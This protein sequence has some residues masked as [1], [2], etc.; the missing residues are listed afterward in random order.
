LIVA[1]GSNDGAK[2]PTW[3]VPATPRRSPY[4]GG[5]TTGFDV[6]SRND[7]TVHTVKLSKRVVAEVCVGK[8]A[9]RLNVARRA[10]S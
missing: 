2:E 3:P 1:I 7:G 10:R 9:T 8:K 6:K 5:C 4:K